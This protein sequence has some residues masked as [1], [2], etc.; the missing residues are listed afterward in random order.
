MMNEGDEPTPTR[1]PRA[2]AADSGVVGEGEQ[3]GVGVELGFLE[4]GYDDG[5]IVE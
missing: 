2:I 3:L 5:S 1:R 4:A